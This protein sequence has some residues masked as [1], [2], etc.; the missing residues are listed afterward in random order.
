MHTNGRSKVIPGVSALYHVE[1][2]SY[3]TRL[4][5]VLV[6]SNHS[7]ALLIFSAIDRLDAACLSLSCV[8]PSSASEDLGLL[9][10]CFG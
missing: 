7:F 8:L 1:L 3:H 10:A 4:L 2:T 6:I 9:L 5:E